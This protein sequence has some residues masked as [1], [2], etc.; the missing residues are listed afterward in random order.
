MQCSVKN[1]KSEMIR[2]ISIYSG[3]SYVANIMY[4][5]RGFLNASIV[6]PAMYGLW[7]G[8]NIILSFGFYAHLGV[9]QG[10]SRE[11]PYSLGKG[12]ER[13]ADAVRDNAFGFCIT[14][15]IVTAVLAVIC[16]L[17]FKESLGLA[18][19]IGIISVSVLMIVSNGIAFYRMALAATKRFSLI[20]MGD[21]VFPVI[22]IILT[23]LLVPRWNI[24]G[25]YAVAVS[26]PIMMFL[27]FYFRTGYKPRVRF[28]FKTVFRLMKI[29]LPLMS[30]SLFPFIL[31]TVDNILILRFLGAAQLGYYALALTI[32]KS[33][34]YLPG[35]V[36]KVTEPRLFHEY[37]E[38]E[39]IESL[40]KYLFVPTKAMATFLPVLIGVI[41]FVS[42]FIIKYFMPQYM[43]SLGPLFII[44]FGKFFLLS[45]P[46]T[47]IFLTAV[48]KQHSVPYFYLIAAFSCALFDTLVLIMGFGLV[49]VALVTAII[50]FLLG[51]SFFLYA[52][53]FYLKKI[54]DYFAICGRIYFPYLTILIF[55]I[56]LN[57]TLR[58]G[59]VFRADLIFVFLKSVILI[60]ISIP[61]ILRL[62]KGIRLFEHIGLLLK[63]KWKVR[64]STC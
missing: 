18:G 30:L 13:K 63:Y 3:S 21:F 23:I 59:D 43:P 49:G 39:K 48:N 16:S 26:C 51:T 28:E 60:G 7:S 50:S 61:F 1:K 36:A 8:L 45:A 33:I 10:M 37:G 14:A 4:F 15:S 6:G 5:L 42:S 58:N 57:L 20:A 31:F 17:F 19:M 34:T 44:L 11:I 62:N 29:G 41:Y 9:L 53:S 2:D 32:F 35:V 64:G 12:D 46:T 47:M 22:Y 55:T 38:T 25:I 54:S 40:K 56:I 24:Y 52:A 27:F